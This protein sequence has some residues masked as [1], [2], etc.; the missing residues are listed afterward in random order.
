MAERQADCGFGQAGAWVHG[1]AFFQA[2]GAVLFLVALDS[3]S[4]AE[5]LAK[6][7]VGHSV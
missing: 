5:E 4:G 6:E 3:V 7:C 1:A 2:D